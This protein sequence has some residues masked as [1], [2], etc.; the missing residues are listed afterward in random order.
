MLTIGI[1]QS[2]M[3][4]LFPEVLMKKEEHI[5]SY[6]ST[7][8]T[9]S[10]FSGIGPSDVHNRA[11]KEIYLI[12]SGAAKVGNGVLAQAGEVNAV[13]CQLVPWRLDFSNQQHNIKQTFRRS[14]FLINRLLGN[15][16]IISSSDFLSRFN[17]PVDKVKEEKRWLSGLY[18]DEPEEWDDPYR[19]F[20]W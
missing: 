3:N 1:D 14:S 11:P 2:E 15:M 8:G 7:F 18:Q 9:L 6:F 4:I 10:L 16:G 12:S 17:S 13:F 19:F 20:R 5:A